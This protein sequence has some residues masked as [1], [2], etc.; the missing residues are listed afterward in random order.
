MLE[1]HQVKAIHRFV[2]SLLA[3]KIQSA[4]G[5]VSNAIVA[6]E[7][8]SIVAAGKYLVLDS[9]LIKLQFDSHQKKRQDELQQ[10]VPCRKRLK[11]LGSGIGLTKKAAPEMIAEKE[12]KGK[13]LI[14]TSKSVL[15]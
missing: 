8:R 13:K 12:K 15:S 3:Y 10:K 14:R 2:Q 1:E 4:H 9:N 7:F 5:V 11:P 6:L